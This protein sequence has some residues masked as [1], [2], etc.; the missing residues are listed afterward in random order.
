MR[1]LVIGAGLSGLAAAERLLDANAEVVIVDSFPRAGGRTAN[2]DVQVPVAG[3]IPGD[4][5]EHGL[6][7]WFQHYHAVFGLMERAGLARPPFA[8]D[9]VNLWN[10]EVGHLEIAGG[11]FVW[12]LNAMRLPRELRGSRRHALTA[13]GRLIGYLERALSN[14]EESDRENAAEL[15]ARMQVPEEAVTSVFGPCMYSLTSLPLAELSALEMLRWMAAIIPDPRIRVLQGGGSTAMCE[16]ILN[17]LARRGAD[18]RMG[19]EVHRLWLDDNGKV[20]AHLERAPDRTG[21]RHI[22][23][24]GFEPAEPPDMSRIDAIVCTLPWERL[25]ALSAG[26]PRLNSLPALGKLHDLKN[27]HPLTV[28]LWFEKPLV[29]AKERYILCRGTLFDV[30]RPTP[31]PERYSDIHLIDCLVEDIDRHVPEIKYQHEAYLTP[32]ATADA[33][34]ERVLADLERMYPGQIRGNRVARSFLHSREGII[35]CNPGVWQLR[36][37]QHIGLK[38]FVLGGDYTKQGWGV[39]MEGATQSGQ[40]AAQALLRG[41]PAQVRPPTY[42]HLLQS[43]K[44]L[45]SASA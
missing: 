36:P 20:Q 11:P 45:V 38:D 21:V 1:V 30:M 5:V 44:T 40:L 19:V 41:Q 33:V 29:D 23:V 10:P 34:T 26:C 28:R 22:L 35:A 4:M 32:G 13:F 14:P 37:P 9:G 16:P 43:I 39:C 6:H 42:S 2:F 15:F 12:L 24:P 18:V 3:L 27:I 8:G 17:Y 7:A 31:E 25:V